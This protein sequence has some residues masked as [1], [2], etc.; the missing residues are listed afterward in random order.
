LGALKPVTLE[1]AIATAAIANEEN[2][3][4]V[5]DWMMCGVQ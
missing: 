5:V 1:A 3:M 4:V 2:F